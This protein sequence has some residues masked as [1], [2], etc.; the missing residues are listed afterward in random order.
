VSSTPSRCTVGV[1]PC[2][3]CDGL[4]WYLRSA[5]IRHFVINWESKQVEEKQ[6]WYSYSYLFTAHLLPFSILQIYSA[7]RCSP[8]INESRTRADDEETTVIQCNTLE[9]SQGDWAIPWKPLSRGTDLRTAHVWARDLTTTNQ[10]D[11]NRSTVRAKVKRNS[12][13]SVCLLLRTRFLIGEVIVVTECKL[14]RCNYGDHEIAVRVKR[15]VV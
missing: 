1:H 9:I 3:F 7:E 10:F 4:Y 13:L 8:V 14:Q 6:Q 5:D 12:E 11:C 2:W 15:N